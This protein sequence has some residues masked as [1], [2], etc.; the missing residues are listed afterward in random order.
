MKISSSFKEKIII[1]AYFTALFMTELYTMEGRLYGN[2]N[3][4]FKAQHA[5][6]PRDSTI[7]VAQR[8]VCSCQ[9]EINP[10]HVCYTFHIKTIF[11]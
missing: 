8:V 10:P 6:I 4:S 5:K 2:N 9:I 3:K 7:K 11:L 1:L